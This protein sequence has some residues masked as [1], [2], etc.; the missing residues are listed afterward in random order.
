M[1]SGDEN[2]YIP[3]KYFKEIKNIY[4]GEQIEIKNAIENNKTDNNTRLSPL[5]QSYIPVQLTGMT[6]IT[7]ISN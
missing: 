4:T 6:P 7:K 1:C 3:I 2:G 5:A